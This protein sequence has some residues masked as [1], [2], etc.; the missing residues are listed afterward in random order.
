MLLLLLSCSE[1][2][3]SNFTLINCLSRNILSLFNLSLHKQLSKFTCRILCNKVNSL[4]IFFQLLIPLILTYNLPSIPRTLMPPTNLLLNMILHLI[5]LSPPSIPSHPL[6]PFLILLSLIKPSLNITHLIINFLLIVSYSVRGAS[7]YILG[8]GTVGL[9][10][11]DYTHWVIW[12][13]VS[14]T[15]SLSLLILPILSFP[16]PFPPLLLKSLIPHIFTF[17]CSPGLE[18]GGLKLAV[19]TSRLTIHILNII[20]S[21]MLWLLVESCLL[22]HKVWDCFGVI[23][24]KIV[25]VVIVYNI[26]NLGLDCF[27]LLNMLLI[28]WLRL[29]KHFLMLLK[30]GCWES[31]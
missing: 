3:V 4:I 20:M 18:V 12:E 27:V 1:L 2:V 21:I 11:T 17:T 14:N 28:G 19:V 31:Y 7:V 23:N 13:G 5:T 15:L 22:K 6:S 8:I 30:L 26:C 9:A 16:S 10:G 29:L 25:N 24:N